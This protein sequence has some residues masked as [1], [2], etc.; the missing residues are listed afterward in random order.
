MKLTHPESDQVIEPKADHADVYLSQG[1]VEAA[2]K[3]AE[4]PEK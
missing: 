1:W 2:E 4:K 3:P